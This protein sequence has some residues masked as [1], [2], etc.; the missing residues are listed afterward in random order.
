LPHPRPW[1]AGS[2]FGAGHR[3]PLD[4]EQRARYRYLLYAHYRAGR[5]PAKQERIGQA[6]L[7]RL[8]TDG[9]LDP[10]H[11]TLAGDAGCSDRTVRRATATLRALG[12]LQWQTRLICAG[13]RV[14]QTS[15]QYLLVLHESLPLVPRCGGQSGRETRRV[16]TESVEQQDAKA[17]ASRDRQLRELG[18]ALEQV[19]GEV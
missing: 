6:L 11:A 15:N 4:R 17:L 10:T 12:L 9:Q 1:R 2:I 3:R 19:R 8:G 7:K 13:R 5:L 18:F 16:S 14:Q